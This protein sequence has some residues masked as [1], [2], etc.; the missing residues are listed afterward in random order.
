MKPNKPKFF[1]FLAPS[2]SDSDCEEGDE[3]AELEDIDTLIRSQFR[4]RGGGGAAPV[5]RRAG[6]ARSLTSLTMGVGQSF[7][8]S[9]SSN[10]GITKRIAPSYTSPPN[11]GGPRPRVAHSAGLS[12][13]HSSHVSLTHTLI[14]DLALQYA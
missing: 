9:P 13:V 3:P 5:S 14:Y 11:A 12:Y 7:I 2:F 10:Q 4:E 1:V 8:I 6:T